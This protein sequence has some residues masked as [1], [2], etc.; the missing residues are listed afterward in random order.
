[1][2][3]EPS[4][5]EQ[6]DAKGRNFL[7]LAIQKCDL[8][9]V[10]FLLSIHVD[11]NSR[12]RDASQMTPLHLAVIAGNEM[13]ARNLLLAGSKVNDTTPQKQTALHL[14]ATHDRATICSILIDNH[15]N[16]DAVDDGINNALHIAVQH[17]HLNSVRI[18]LKQSN[19]NVE[20]INMRGQN[21]LHILGQ[22]GK[23]NAAAIFEFILQCRPQFP[24]DQ[25][26]ANG[27]TVLLL[28]YFNGNGSL[29][30]AVVKA[31]AQLGTVNRDGLSIF[32]TPVATKQ[33][34]FKLLDM[35]AKEPPWCEGE[36]CLECG[37]RFGIKTRKHHCRHCGRILC[38]KCSEKDMPIIKYNILK[39]VRICGICFDVLTLSSAS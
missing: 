1:L 18:L 31:G 2:D 36:V 30:R 33:L 19:I 9:A 38:S 25:L 17:G 26:D 20:A 7:H 8:E 24:I 23:E 15:I 16:C 12:V 37:V 4:A 39:P 32:N 29:C 10:L 5:A 13:I 22:F 11:V 6:F 21:I 3:R 35:L 27:N 34:L 14:A 28:A